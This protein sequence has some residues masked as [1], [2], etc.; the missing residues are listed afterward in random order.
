[1]ACADYTAAGG[2]HA[3]GMAANYIERT[4]GISIIFLVRSNAI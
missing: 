3:A 2:I 1:M 4:S